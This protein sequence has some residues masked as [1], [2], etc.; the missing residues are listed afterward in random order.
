VAAPDTP[1]T[2]HPDKETEMAVT[3][4]VLKDKCIGSG[5]CVSDGA[6]VFHFDDD[7]LAEARGNAAALSAEQ[8][9]DIAQ[10][11]PAAAIIINKGV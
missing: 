7:G 3:V 10:N 11:C 6:P 8:L 4:E 9:R 5:F 1:K 2:E